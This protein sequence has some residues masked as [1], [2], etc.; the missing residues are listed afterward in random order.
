MSGAKDKAVGDQYAYVI[1][2]TFIPY[3]YLV[4]ALIMCR[5]NGQVKELERAYDVQHRWHRTDKDYKV[6]LR[7]L[8]LGK[9]ESILIALLKNRQ[10]REFLLNFRRKYA[11][12]MNKVVYLCLVYFF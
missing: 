12:K 6:C 8:S 1:I 7:Y 10:R 11:G 5:M 2:Q 9:R 3:H 4:C